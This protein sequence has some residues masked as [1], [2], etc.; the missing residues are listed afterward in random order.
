MNTKKTPE[1]RPG[2]LY[3]M[4]S[5]CYATLCEIAKGRAVGRV[6]LLASTP[7]HDRGGYTI[8]RDAAYGCH[9]CR[10]ENM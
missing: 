3:N 6:I 8:Y 1:R 5:M 4:C 10:P 7:Y 2:D 9:L